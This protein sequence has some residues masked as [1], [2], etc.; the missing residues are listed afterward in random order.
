MVWIQF[1]ATSSH[2]THD[3]PPLLLFLNLRESFVYVCAVIES[4]Y[5]VLSFQGVHHIHNPISLKETFSDY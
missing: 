1:Q 2:L 5:M 4:T 3:L